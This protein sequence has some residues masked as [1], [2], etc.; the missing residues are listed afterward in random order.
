[1]GRDHEK[2]PWKP[3]TVLFFIGPKYPSPSTTVFLSLSLRRPTINSCVPSPPTNSTKFTALNAALPFL[4]SSP[5]RRHWFDDTHVVSQNSFFSS[6]KYC[7]GDGLNLVVVV[8]VVVIVVVVVSE[9]HDAASAEA[10]KERRRVTAGSCWNRPKLLPPTFELQIVVDKL[11]D[12][13]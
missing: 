12:E 11:R 9:A 3:W 4:G 8:V 6:G 7:N 13:R 2:S 1:M 5:L 10:T